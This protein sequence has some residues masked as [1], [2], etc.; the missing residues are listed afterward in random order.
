MKRLH[1][2]L[3]AAVALASIPMAAQ[4]AYPDRPIRLVVGF[5]AGGGADNVARA[6]ADAMGR[7]LGQ[8]V[9]VDN[10]PGAGTTLAAG[11]VARAPADGYTLMMLTSTNTISPSMYKS[12]SYDAA[13]AFSMVSTV[14]RGPLLIAVP[15][16]SGIRTLADLLA[17][18]RQ[19]PGKLNYGAGGVGTTPHLAALVLQRDAGVRMAHIPYKGGSETATALVG[20]Q[21]DVQFGTP[22]AVAPI[23]SRANVLAVA[24]AR[25]TPL[26][27]GVPAAA[28]TVKGYEVTSWYGI[29]GPAGMPPEVVGTLSRAVHAALAD[30]RLRQQ[31]T[32]LGVEAAPS[33][34]AQ[35]DRLYTEELARWAEVVRSEGLQSDQ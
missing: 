32:L 11:T 17:R 34:P 19:A 25:R 27:P 1:A 18:A 10:R 20:G 7:S 14:A 30:E 3:L 13:T 12:L 28:E 8:T 31:F 23:A 33:S 2:T 9:I 24:T 26:A 4:A 6:L 35:A 21:L 5:G 22:P 16:D 29:G 15:K